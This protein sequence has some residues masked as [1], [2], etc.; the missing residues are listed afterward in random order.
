MEQNKKIIFVILALTLLVAGCT[1]K[2]AVQSRE[3][4]P[5]E[6]IDETIYIAEF[7]AITPDTIAL[8]YLSGNA[9]LNLKVNGSDINIKGKLRIK[10]GEGIQISI[11]PLGLIE[12]AC[13][14]F[15][16]QKIR[17][18][19]KL[20]KT[21][22]EVPYS[23]AAAIGL[24]GV[25]YNVLEAIFL[26]YAFLPDGRLAHKGLNELNVEKQEN[27]YLLN[28]KKNTAMKYS[29]LIDKNSG[30]LVSCSG[31]SSSG[32]SIKCDYSNFDNVGNISFPNDICIN[33]KGDTTIKL[34]F[35]LNKTN[36]KSFTFSTRSINNSYRKQSVG[37]FIK[38]IK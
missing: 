17:F 36:N 19:N 32:E 6:V 15:L 29:F 13:V 28:T 33:F 16:P 31:L 7:P 9:D 12:A 25:N 23:E 26:N 27:H 21:Y 38:S 8:K 22:T 4:E 10:R 3:S 35:E 14:E 24:A 5:V 11:T 18:I 20:F 34:N 37:D 1:S 2:R 30:S